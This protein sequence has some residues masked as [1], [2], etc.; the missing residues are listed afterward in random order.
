[1]TADVVLVERHAACLVLT[2]NRPE[3]RNALTDAVLSGLRRGLVE[4][5][6]D[7]AVRAVVVTGAGDE[8]FCAGGDLSAMGGADPFEA[9]KGRAE[10]AALFRDLWELG[11]PTIARVQG[12]AMA[13]GFGIA[14]AC[15]IVIASERASFGVPEATV[16]IWPYMI[17]V[18]LLHCL[19]P[20]QALRLMMTG[21]RLSAAEGLKLGFVTEV[22]A[23][24]GLDAAVDA[25]VGKLMAASPQALALG[26]TAFYAVL[27]HD[28]DARLRML[29]ALLTVNLSMPD[30]AEGFAAFR[31][32][33]PPSWR[34]G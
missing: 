2:I 12:P 16:G 1:M 33:R 19:S 11:K 10:L 17:T 21:E 24:A 5:K 18:P 4:A 15:D 31:E 27:N 25:W 28:V 7:P 26:R 13:G 22:V 29:E 8:A 6:A 32:K 3:R 9:H 34:G 14:A 23:H 30:A 20:K